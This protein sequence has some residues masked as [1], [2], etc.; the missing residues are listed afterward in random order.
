MAGYTTTLPAQAAAGATSVT[1]VG[2]VHTSNDNAARITGVFVAAPSLVTGVATNN[3][4]INVRSVKA[5][6][7]TTFATLTLGA[8]TNL[9]AST[10]VAV[11]ITVAVTPAAG[12]VYDVQL[13]QNG[14]GLALP[15]G[16]LAQIVLD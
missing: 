16:I 12:D 14:T 8:G 13:V 4:T 10:A 1:S 6:T 2:I 11:P 5:G 9:P 3:A 7:P 15:A